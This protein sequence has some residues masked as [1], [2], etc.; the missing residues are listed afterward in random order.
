M[1]DDRVAITDE[2]L[3]KLKFDVLKEKVDDISQQLGDPGRYFASFKA[4]DLLDHADCERIKAEI[5]SI[6]KATKL[7]SM[8]DNRKGRKG[9][10]PYDVLASA[11][12]KM[13]VHV[14]IVRILNEELAKKKS[15]LKAIKSESWLLVK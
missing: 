15:E 12:K 11:L 4:K 6:E 3:S 1:A 5:T 2:E 13:R 7:I 14:H 8:L 9:E 10:H